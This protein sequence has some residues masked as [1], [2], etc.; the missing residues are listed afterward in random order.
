MY[1]DNGTFPTAPGKPVNFEFVKKDLQKLLI[2]L[3]G[4][5]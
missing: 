2:T 1:Y 5:G 4:Q 3:G